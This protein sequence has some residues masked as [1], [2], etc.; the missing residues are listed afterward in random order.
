MTCSN[1][2][3]SLLLLL[4]LLF[5]LGFTL[6]LALS[7]AHRFQEA[8]AASQEQAAS[9]LERKRLCH[10]AG[11]GRAPREGRM[12]RKQGSFFASAFGPQMAGTCSSKS[13]RCPTPSLGHLS[14]G[15]SGQQHPCS[16]SLSGSQD[17]PRVRPCR[18]C[19]LCLLCLEHY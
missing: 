9:Q 2:S 4:L 5:F 1:D 19:F 18:D 7:H 12:S 14:V 15:P 13:E 10:R 6:V 11:I 8:A 17:L 3:N 16:C